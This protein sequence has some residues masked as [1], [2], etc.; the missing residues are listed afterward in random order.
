MF[1]RICHSTINSFMSFGKMP[2]ANGFLTQDKIND[3]YLFELKPV[4]CEHCFSFQIEEQPAPEMMFHDHYAFFSRSSV[5]MQV[6]FK[7]YASWVG[8]TYLTGEDPFVVELGSNDGIMLENFAKR[9]IRHLGV[10]PSANVAEEARKYGVNTV[11]KFFGP[12]TA[13]EIVDEYGQANALIAANVM[14]H[15]PDMNGIARG[16]DLLL[17]QDGVLIFEDPYLGAMIEKTSYDQ[18]YDEHVFIFS[19]L[20]VANIFDRYGFELIDLMPQHTHGGS[21]RY[22]LARKGVRTISSAV[23]SIINAEKTAGLHLPETYEQFRNNCEKSKE[24]LVRILKEEKA[25]GRRVVGYGATSKS[26]TI[27]NYCGIGP[28]LIEFISDT[29]PIKQNKLTPGTHIPV[30]PYEAFTANYPDTALLFAWNHQTEIMEK[31]KD[32]SAKGGRWIIP[33]PEVKVL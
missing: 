31:E 28:D 22:V 27:L 1:C 29:T 15:I 7:E 5:F 32:F 17:K 3:E 24:D 20:S 10:E 25:A 16:A 13:T 23:S 2:V 18:I 6:H 21:M 11:V 30:K 19:A 14:C 4:F 26:T 12:A 9:G 8:D 33:V